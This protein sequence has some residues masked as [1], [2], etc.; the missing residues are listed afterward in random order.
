[1]LQRC[2]VSVRDS[3]VDVWEVC[4][5]SDSARSETIVAGKFK[6]QVISSYLQ[7]IIRLIRSFSVITRY[8]QNQRQA[9]NVEKTWKYGI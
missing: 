6:L 7:V 2:D 1:M 9:C 8:V 5:D 3:S 4:F